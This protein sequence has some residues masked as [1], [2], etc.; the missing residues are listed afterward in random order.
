MSAAAVLLSQA[1]AALTVATVPRAATAGAARSAVFMAAGDPALIIQ[2]KGGGHGEFGALPPEP[3]VMPS[4]LT[5]GGHF[6]AQGTTWRW[7]WP[8]GRAGR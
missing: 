2:N 7:G 3:T 6:P 8:M 1:A 5:R 4:C